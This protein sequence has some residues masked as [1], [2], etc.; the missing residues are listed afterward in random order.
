MK[1]DI[2][3]LTNLLNYNE[4]ALFSG[5][6]DHFD[7]IKKFEDSIDIKNCLSLGPDENEMKQDI[8]MY[9]TAPSTSIQHLKTS[10]DFNPDL[11]CPFEL[12]PIDKNVVIFNA[13][14]AELKKCKNVKNTKTIII[15]ILGNNLLIT[16][17]V[18]MLY[19]YELLY[20]PMPLT[21]VSISEIVEGIFQLKLS[22]YR[23]LLIRACPGKSNEF[24]NEIINLKKQING[25]CI[26]SISE[27]TIK[28]DLAS[29]DV[30]FFIIYIGVG[31]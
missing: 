20:P 8:F 9:L 24:I 1:S 21:H 11:F 28:S 25:K 2:D 5:Y 23:M 13:T 22:P 30:C 6:Q 7:D 4:G 27:V 19:K 14:K 15:H 16:K 26:K 31:C 12:L 10:L 29:I 18:D 17:K 3:S